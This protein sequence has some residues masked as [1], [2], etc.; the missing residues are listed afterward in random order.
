MQKEALRLTD[1]SLAFPLRA[2]HRLGRGPHLPPN[3]GAGP[4]RVNAEFYTPV[5]NSVDDMWTVLHSL[6][7][8]L[9]EGVD[10]PVGDTPG[11]LAGRCLTSH[12]D[13]AH[14]VDGK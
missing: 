13:R 11:R 4:G 3:L 10:R 1:A 12:N 5:D 8:L 7:M 2:P 14:A 9:W 6:W